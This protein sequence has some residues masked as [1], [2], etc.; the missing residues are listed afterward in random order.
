MKSDEFQLVTGDLPGLVDRI[1]GL[2]ADYYTH[3]WGF[4]AFFETRVATE[5]KEFFKRYNEVRDCT[6]SVIVD[7]QVEEQRYETRF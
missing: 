1:T 6:W 4:T 7:Q 5:M 3:Y 2:H